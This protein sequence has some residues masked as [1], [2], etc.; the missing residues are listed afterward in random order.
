[1]VKC[2]IAQDAL[3]FVKECEAEW[4]QECVWLYCPVGAFTDLTSKAELLEAGSEVTDQDGQSREVL[5]Y[6]D[7]AIKRTDYVIDGITRMPRHG[8]RIACG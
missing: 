8:D 3:D 5:R 4:M 2:N 6:Q 7:F 1:M